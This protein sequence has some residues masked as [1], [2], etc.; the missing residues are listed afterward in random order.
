M[1]SK[2]Y[3]ELQEACDAVLIPNRQVPK[4]SISNMLFLILQPIRFVI[5]QVFLDITL[6][7]GGRVNG[8]TQSFL[9]RSSG[10]E[11]SRLS[12]DKT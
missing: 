12:L 4:Q 10:L 3:F 8:I 2:M 7:W 5:T 11:E 1:F 9:T 6:V